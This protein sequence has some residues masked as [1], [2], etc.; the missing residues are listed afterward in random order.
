MADG[1]IQRLKSSGELPMPPGVVLKILEL[2]READGS[3]AELAD[4]IALDPG[5]SAKILRFA[6]SPLSGVSRE[7]TSLR[8]AVALMGLRG[9]K[10]MALSFSIVPSGKANACAGFDPRH[11]AIHSLGCAAAAKTFAELTK[12]G[13]A[14]DAFSAGLL[15]QLGRSI[16]ASSMPEEYAAIVARAD[17]IPADLPPL[18]RAAWGESYATVGGTILRSWGLPETMCNAVSAFRDAEQDPDGPP[19]TRLLALAERAADLVCPD[20]ADRRLD[21]GAYLDCAKAM[22]R[23]SSET[24]LGALSTIASEVDQVRAVIEVPKANL[25]SV[26]EIEGEV[27]ERIVEL[28]LAMHLENQNMAMQQ[29]ELLRRATTDGLTGVGNRAAFDARLGLELERA[30]REGGPLTLLMMDV[31]RFK[32]FNDTF[33]HPV[34]DQVLQA[35]ARALDENVRKVDFVARYGGEEFAVIA[36]KSSRDHGVELAERLRKGVAAASVPFETGSL[37]VTISVGVAV[38]NDASDPS[39]DA[40]NLIKVADR[41]LYLAKRNGRNRVEAEDAVRTPAVQ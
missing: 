32:K 5:L 16:L 2:T 41:L 7:V 24:A 31:D 18:E 6:N 9:V 14:Q 27:R 37:S 36:P 19:L 22:F 4:T 34:G 17:R 40:P 28:S 33:G 39:T 3:V 29:E 38:L 35:V 1:L 12:T 26:E 15:S 11:F 10:M 13:N 20:R 8:Q 23:L 30:L 21:A 25:R